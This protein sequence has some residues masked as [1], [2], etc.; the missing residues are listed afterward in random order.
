M[1]KRI[2]ATN[3]FPTVLFIL[4]E[5]FNGKVRKRKGVLNKKEKPTYEWVVYGEDAER[6]LARMLPYLVEK[7]YQAWLVLEM[8]KYPANSEQ[9]KRM[10]EEL[11]GAKWTSY[12]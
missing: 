3:T 10:K 8:C 7:R 1:Y 4:K 11:K 9:H 12:D 5:V 2:M 6:C